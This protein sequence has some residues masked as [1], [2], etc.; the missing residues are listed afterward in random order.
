MWRI[1]ESFYNRDWRGDY[2]P[3]GKLENLLEYLLK[4][5]PSQ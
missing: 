3:W 2:E 4:A 5:A 1:E